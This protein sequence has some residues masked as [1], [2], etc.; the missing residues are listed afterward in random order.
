L[1]AWEQSLTTS[2]G[3]LW[4]RP[5]PS[6]IV[7]VIGGRITRGDVPELCERLRR[8]VER[9]YADV[10][11]FE[12][13]ALVDPDVDT[14]AAMARLALTARR[15]GR[16]LRL[17]QASRHLQE[18]LALTGLDDVIQ[19]SAEL[20]PGPRGQAEQREQA[21]SVKEEVESD[22]PTV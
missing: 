4:P 17:R 11:E 7:V 6:T 14:V 3:G 16:Q 20:R 15:L 13:G 1:V 21:R 5:A 19:C 10:I 12:V 8:A 22:D 2:S 9:S 18:L